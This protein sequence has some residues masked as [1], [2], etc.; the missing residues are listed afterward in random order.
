[1]NL[2]RFRRI[3]AALTQARNRSGNAR[4]LTLS[5]ASTPV[6]RPV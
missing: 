3:T 4:A 6:R 5:R 1:M 2:A